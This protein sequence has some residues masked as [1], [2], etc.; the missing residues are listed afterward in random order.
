MASTIQTQYSAASVTT[1]GA[2]LAIASLPANK[3]PQGQW[4]IRAAAVYVG[5][6]GT[7]EQASGGNVALYVGATS[8]PLGMPAIAGQMFNFPPLDLYLDGS[9]VVSVGTSSA[10]G[11]SGVTYDCILCMDQLQGNETPVFSE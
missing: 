2:F 4:R 10:V 1:P 5:T 3:L 11:S 9:T 7:A 6:I 8:I